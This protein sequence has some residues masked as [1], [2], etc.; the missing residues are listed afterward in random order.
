MMSCSIPQPH[1]SHRP[2]ILSALYLLTLSQTYR[3]SLLTF[4]MLQAFDP[5]IQRVLCLV[6]LLVLC[7]DAPQIPLLIH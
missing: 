3:M 1:S 7:H 4:S 6:L 5:I 2:S